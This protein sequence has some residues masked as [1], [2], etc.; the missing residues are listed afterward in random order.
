MRGD[1]A[2]FDPSPWLVFSKVILWG[3]NHYSSKLP[4]D[5]SWLVWDKREG[6]SSNRLSDCELA[7]CSEGSGVR[8]FRCLWNGLCRGSEAGETSFHPT[9]K[10]VA[11]MRW[12]LERL[13]L[14]S[15]DLVFDPF[16]GSG[17]VGVAA[18]RMGL[19]YVGCEVDPT[20]FE[21]GL[22]R[23]RKETRGFGLVR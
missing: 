18:M 21:T 15:G 10:P 13:G 6:T 5:G 17:T 11:L 7:W 16:A 23:L 1:D 4:D 3:S 20:H 8:I 2:P 14:G 12:C 19:K 22:N 9:Q